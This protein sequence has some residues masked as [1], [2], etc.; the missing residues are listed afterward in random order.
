MASKMQPHLPL[1]DGRWTKPVVI[2]GLALVVIPLGVFCDFY[3]AARGELGLAAVWMMITL[4]SIGVLGLYVR[5]VNLRHQLRGQDEALD[6]LQRE[7]GSMRQS[8]EASIQ[9]ANRASVLPDVPRELIAGRLN[10]ETPPPTK[11]EDTPRLKLVGGDEPSTADEFPEAAGTAD[12]PAIPSTSLA[13]R[14]TGVAAE[15]PSS[16]LSPNIGRL[17]RQ[18]ALHVGDEDFADALTAGEEIAVAFPHSAA[19]AEFRR[20]RP[21]LLR[22]LGSTAG[23]DH[24]I[25]DA[26]HDSMVQASA[27]AE[28]DPPIRAL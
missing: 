13:D 20:L 23:A 17:R 11:T 12:R 3:Y 9:H 2:Y 26:V 16:S 5:F 14:R 28:R 22:R 4:C 10:T 8:A 24:L 25:A 7:L 27:Q 6:R 1:A 18:F 19:A 21:I 15:S